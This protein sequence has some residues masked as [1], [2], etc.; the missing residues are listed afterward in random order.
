MSKNTK[1]QITC[2][3]VSAMLC[4]LGVVILGLGAIIEVI[5]LSVSVIASL[6]VVY[7]VIEMGGIYPWMIWLVTS[8]VAFLLLPLKTPVLFYAMLAGFYPILKEKIEKR[9][10]LLIGWVLKLGILVGSVGSIYAVSY[11][12]IPQLLVGYNS[13]PYL[14]AFFALALLCFVLYDV[15][16]T[17]L[18]TFYFVKL[19]KRLHLK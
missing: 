13:L 4:A 7:A 17:R 8:I 10:T 19:Q 2:L 3:T 16:L 1:K 18:I 9:C 14:L 15:C 5:D 11:F 12:F 6:L